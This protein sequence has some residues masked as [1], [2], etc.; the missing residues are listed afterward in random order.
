LFCEP[1]PEKFEFDA[2]KFNFLYSAHA[3]AEEIQ[4]EEIFEKSAGKI[5]G[6]INQKTT[7]IS[8]WELMTKQA[9]GQIFTEIL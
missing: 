9:R 8:A 3:V 6:I 7:T 5:F 1:F 2:K 4:G